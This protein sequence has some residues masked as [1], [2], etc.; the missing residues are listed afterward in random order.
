MKISIP[1]TP[2]RYRTSH[3][4][5]NWHDWCGSTPKTKGKEKVCECWCHKS[6]ARYREWI[7][8]TKANGQEVRDR[9]Y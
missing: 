2:K 9:G 7:K 5:N 1:V 3:C 6:K 8:A 4:K